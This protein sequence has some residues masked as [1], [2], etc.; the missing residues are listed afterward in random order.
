MRGSVVFWLL[1]RT[2]AATKTADNYIGDYA[3]RLPARARSFSSGMRIVS[4]GRG[5]VATMTNVNGLNES[6]QRNKST[7]D[8]LITKRLSI[9]RRN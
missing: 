6:T 4:T 8:T 2:S 1:D 9:A 3:F 7:V 5:T